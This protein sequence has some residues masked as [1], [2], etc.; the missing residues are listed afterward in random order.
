LPKNRP[1]FPAGCF[2][3][4]SSKERELSLQTKFDQTVTSKP[5]GSEEENVVSHYFS[6]QSFL[7]LRVVD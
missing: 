4:E 7:L 1:P 5:S 3:K 2:Y 6:F